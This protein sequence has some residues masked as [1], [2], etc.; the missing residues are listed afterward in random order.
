M[1]LPHLLQRGTP[2]PSESPGSIQGGKGD[3]QRVLS[4]TLGDLKYEQLVDFVC[5][6]RGFRGGGEEEEEDEDGEEGAESESKSW[7]VEE[8]GG[9]VPEEEDV[10]EE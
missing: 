6:K 3:F 9:D 8:E 7:S 2:P 5:F 4:L 10:I 1:H